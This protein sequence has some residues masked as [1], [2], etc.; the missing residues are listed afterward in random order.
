MANHLLHPDFVGAYVY[1]IIVN[2]VVRYIGKGRRY[3]AIEHFRKAREL[4]RRRAKGEK[5]KALPFHN[6]LAK[7]MRNGV[8]VKYKILAKNLSDDDAFEREVAEISSYPRC[9][10]WNV[11]D[12]GRGGLGPERMRALW[13]D[14]EYRAKTLA[15]QA[16]F[17]TDEFCERQRQHANEKWSDPN[18]RAAWMAQ[19]RKIW[20]DPDRSSKQRAILKAV[21]ADPIRAEKKRQLVK[22]QWTPERRLAMA[23]NRRKAW[24]DPEFKKRVSAA[25]R[26]SKAV[27]EKYDN[28]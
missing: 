20:D 15:G 11:L 26:R 3:R 6:K 25:L 10:L 2:G 24:S 19:H 17:R 22:S 4:N 27:R 16:A 9:Q 18:Y 13:R 28:S 12:G 1:A 21:W 23:E 7:A 5:I 14:P 8:S